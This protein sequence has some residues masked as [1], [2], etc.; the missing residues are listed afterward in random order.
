MTSFN[1][2]SNQYYITILYYLILYFI[3]L[4]I[5]FDSFLK[6]LDIILIIYFL[7]YKN[8]QQTYFKIKMYL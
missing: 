5:L 1:S 2:K 8:H 7:N 6:Y 3:I 4:Y